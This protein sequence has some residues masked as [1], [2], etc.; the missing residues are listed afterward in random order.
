[1][2]NRSYFYTNQKVLK[3]EA[4]AWDSTSACIDSEDIQQGPLGS[5][6][7]QLA[8]S[9]ARHSSRRGILRGSGPG[10]PTPS[11]V[12]NKSGM[13]LTFR[14]SRSSKRIL[15]GR[16]TVKDGECCGVWDL[17][18]SYRA[19]VGPKR[20]WLFCSRVR[21]CD[22]HVADSHQYLEVRFRNGNKEHKRG[23]LAMFE[24][25]VAHESI[26]V[27]NAVTVDAFEVVVVYTEDA[28][29]N[30]KRNIV[31]GP[32]VFIP[33][34]TQWLHVFR[35]HGSKGGD[36]YT[37]VPGALVFTKLRTIPD[38]FYYN[39]QG[40][41]TSDDASLTVKVMIFYSLT[42]I[43]VMLNSTHDPIGDF[44]NALLADLMNFSSRHTYEQ[45][46][47]C[48][49]QLSDLSTFPVLCSRAEAVGF[50]IGKVVYRGY[51]ASD[52]LQSLCD[53]AIRTRTE[54]KLKQEEQE[55]RERMRS[56]ELT[57]SHSRGG[58]ERTEEAARQVHALQLEA[59]AHSAALRRAEEAHAERMRQERE[60]SEVELQAKRAALEAHTEYLRGLQQMGVDLTKYLVACEEK[61]PD[62]VFKVIGG[63]GAATGAAGGGFNI[64]TK[65]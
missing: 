50:K 46:I 1:M 19:V 12:P 65:V 56:L 21:F 41:R 60:T 62:K 53:Q 23:P 18:G 34:V 44:I 58:A 61:Q 13:G 11:A 5:P 27:M 55:Q 10:A 40:V 14:D 22:R 29:G 47:Q 49:Q 38:Q 26:T 20:Q 25:P 57:G 64:H 45:F 42:N 9:N 37:K 36:Q 2:D 28:Q 32:T 63:Q 35:W 43:E 8:L 48:A 24:D 52:Q 16:R 59:E 15:V 54:M 33:E 31:H 30:V 6:Q 17:S 3:K 39:A 4:P 7:L 51:Q